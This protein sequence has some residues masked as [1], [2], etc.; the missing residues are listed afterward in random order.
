M[1]L[2][3]MVGVALTTVEAR[4]CL[5]NLVYSHMQ[6]RLWR[7]NL[8]CLTSTLGFILKSSRAS[9]CTKQTRELRNYMSILL[10]EIIPLCPTQ[11]VGRKSYDVK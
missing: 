11:Y 10:Y 2:C 3:F 9:K 6:I 8:W 5:L 7:R 4:V 1:W